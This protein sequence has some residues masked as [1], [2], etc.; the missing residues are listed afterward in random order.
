MNYYF[1]TYE[2]TS[3]KCTWLIALIS[4]SFKRLMY[5][6]IMFDGKSWYDARTVSTFWS[7]LRQ[8][9]DI[10]ISGKEQGTRVETQTGNNQ[11]Y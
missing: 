4:I 1:I 8:N 3:D 5:H 11:L 6:N 2:D 7:T 9:H 10:L